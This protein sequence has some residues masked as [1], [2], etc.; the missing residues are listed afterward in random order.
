[1]CIKRVKLTFSYTY[2]RGKSMA[3][4]TTMS[5]NGPVYRYFK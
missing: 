5:I 2:A 1:M 3:P 4:F